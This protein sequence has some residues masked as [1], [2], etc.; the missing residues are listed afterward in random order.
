MEKKLY[1]AL[2]K[3]S[4]EE[5]RILRGE[6]IDKALYTRGD[7]FTVNGARLD[8]GGEITARLHTRYTEFP[9]HKH[10]FIELMTVQSG[11]ITHR[12]NG[13]QITLTEGDILFINK[14]L[15]HSV[16]KAEEYDLGVNVIMS[17]RFASALAPRLMGTVFY[18]LIRSNSDKNGDGAYL[19]FR[20]GGDRVV[21]NLVEN[22]L[23]SLTYG[24]ETSSILP[25][26]VELLMKALSLKSDRLLLDGSPLVCKRSKR[27]NDITAYI[28][29]SYR[30]ATLGELAEATDLSVPYLS[31]EIKRLFGKSF[32]ELLIEE[33]MIRA[34]ELI[35]MT[36]MPIGE[37]IR[38]VGYENESYFHREYK[39]RF[40]ITPLGR[41][42]EK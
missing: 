26:S 29:S 35:L 38:S 11:R 5:Q 34:D 25:E 4:D 13:K 28:K 22:I 23:I 41:R 32:G 7:G 37:V 16:D 10:T 24:A 31:C 17:D 39:R 14:H 12:I 33:R 3:N 8:G 20:C 9:P 6:G 30:T 21:E 42:K 2:A 27:Q 40:G 1:E 15:T 19:Y 18:E 36:D